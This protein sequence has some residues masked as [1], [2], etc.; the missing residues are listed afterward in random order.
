M[1]PHAEICYI[2]TVNSEEQYGRY[3][4]GFWY[5]D[6]AKFF[7]RYFVPSEPLTIRV[8]PDH[9][10]KSYVF[11]EDQTWWESWCKGEPR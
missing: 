5:D 10:E 9:P 8:C 6:S 11:E 1:Y 3:K 4:R 7:A 2:Y